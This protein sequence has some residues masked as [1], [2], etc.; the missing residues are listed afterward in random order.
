[1][2]KNNQENKENGLGSLI[3]NSEKTIKKFYEKAYVFS[4]I[5]NG[6]PIVY[7]ELYCEYCYRLLGLV[8]NYYNALELTWMQTRLY[9]GYDGDVRIRRMQAVSNAIDAKIITRVAKYGL[10]SYPL[11][12][13]T[14]MALRHINNKY[15]LGKILKLYGCGAMLDKGREYRNISLLLIEAKNKNTILSKTLTSK[16]NE[17]SRILE[18]YY[19]SETGLFAQLQH[20]SKQILELGKTENGIESLDRLSLKLGQKLKSLE[21]HNG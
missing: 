20:G 5:N 13:I 6:N 10:C 1:M 19:A 9:D 8:M 4:Q 16:I 3:Q 15:N 7:H 18:W 21:A 12:Q 14:R 11:C 17:L 2:S